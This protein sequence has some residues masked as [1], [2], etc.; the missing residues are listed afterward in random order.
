MSA[1]ISRKI[2]FLIFFA[3][4]CII[5]AVTLS[6]YYL[7]S[8]P[9]LG[10]HYDF[11]RSRRA[12]PVAR[13][14]LLI[15]TG[16]IIENR[17]L[18]S[19]LMVMTEMG[20]SSLLLEAPLVRASLPLAMGEREIQRQFDDEFEILGANIRNFFDAIRLGSISPVAAPLYVERLVELAEEGRDRLSSMFAAHY[21]ELERAAVIFGSLWEAPPPHY[22][23]VF[24]EINRVAPFTGDDVHPVLE[25]LSS[26]W[27]YFT[28][29]QNGEPG[30][31]G[32]ILG[33]R[34]DPFLVIR[35]TDGSELIIN[36]DSGRNILIDK[37]AAP[38]RMIDIQTILEYDRLQREMRELLAVAGAQGAF[39]QTPPQMIPL[40]L[41]DRAQEARAD[42]L[43][44][45]SA[46]AKNNWLFARADYFESLDAFLFAAGGD[47]AGQEALQEVQETIAAMKETHAELAALRDFLRR[48]L[49]LSYGIMGHISG[50]SPAYAS[51]LLANALLTGG[52]VSAAQSRIALA[53][54]FAAA[55][56]ILILTYSMRP[57]ATLFFGLVFTAAFA[58]AMGWSFVLTGYW[59][60]PLMLALAS[61][62]GLLF[63][64]FSKTGIVKKRAARLSAIYGQAVPKPLLQE[65]I[66]MDGL[67][68]PQFAVEKAAV[69]AVKDSSLAGIE[70]KEGLLQAEKARAQFRQKVREVFNASGAVIAGGYDDQV[71][72]CFGS[73]PQRAV[74][75]KKTKGKKK[76]VSIFADYHPADNSL[77]IVRRLLKD[78]KNTWHFGLDYGE[79]SFS[80]SPATGYLAAGGP[81]SRARTLSAMTGRAKTRALM[82]E[83]VFE[84]SDLPARRMGSFGK[85]AGK[86]NG[87]YEVN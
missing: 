27:E 83:S 43:Y 51:A 70:K 8:P 16:E 28:L 1:Q 10:P 61:C 15:N 12:A 41:H 87:V 75:K 33:E 14:I 85:E 60:D 81:V 54:T 44:S 39:S 67:S 26:R 5:A 64:F 74:L 72:V 69:I 78:S 32:L 84:K 68:L 37:P 63:V 34:R 53:A 45:P 59:I 46:E 24:G 40:F 30:L 79:C 6:A 21:E 7:L 48:E 38:F 86:A 31:A 36:L 49:A 62:A 9:R 76:P 20:A 11:F 25:S 52:H 77:H 19:A 71:L 42:L 22:K 65:L 82:T 35:Q 80:W 13:E 17:E 73:P 4:L 23:A 50:Q 57:W 56:L 29:D 18:F 58:F 47:E 55:L 2:S 3:G 66:N